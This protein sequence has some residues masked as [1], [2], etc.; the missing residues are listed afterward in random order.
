MLLG[1]KRKKEPKRF[2]KVIKLWLNEEESRRIFH[3]A[4]MNKKKD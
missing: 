3:R 2:V 1:S 4:Q